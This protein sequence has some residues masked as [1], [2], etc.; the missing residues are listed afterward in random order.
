MSVSLPQRPFFL[1]CHDLAAPPQLFPEIEF[2]IPPRKAHKGKGKLSAFRPSFNKC[3]VG[4]HAIVCWYP[5]LPAPLPSGAHTLQRE[6]WCQQTHRVWSGTAAGEGW[7]RSLETQTLGLAA[8]RLV[9]NLDFQA[10]SQAER[11]HCQQG[12][13]AS[14]F[15]LFVYL[16]IYLFIYLFLGPHPWHME[17]PRLGVK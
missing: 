13:L 8:G 17:V 15:C 4:A 9:Q 6:Q 12:F 16:F 11:I 1:C 10:P 2:F 7:A 3:F 5:K 14:S